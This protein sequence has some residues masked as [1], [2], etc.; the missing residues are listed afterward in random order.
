MM[1]EH[2][3]SRAGT[4][5]GC[6]PFVL[7]GLVVL[8]AIAVGTIF[9]ARQIKIGPFD[10]E[11][12]EEIYFI[13]EYHAYVA[14]ADRTDAHGEPLSDVLAILRRDRE[15]Y[16]APKIRQQGDTEE[17]RLNIGAFATEEQ[18]AELSR[19]ELSIPDALKAQLLTRDMRVRVLVH[20]RA[21]D[22]RLLA[23]VSI[24]RADGGGS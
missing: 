6:L 23:A 20:S 11:P 9:L 17:L 18:R 3:P 2:E 14:E 4:P 5:R 13:T 24:P 22:S 19:A 15:N 16:H 21:R 7:A 8:A 10:E 1:Q 12:Q